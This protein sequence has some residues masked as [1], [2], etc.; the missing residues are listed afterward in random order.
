MENIATSAKK[1]CNYHFVKG[2]ERTDDKIVA[3]KA[4]CVLFYTLGKGSFRMLA[5]IFNTQPSLVYR[6]IMEAGAKLS[7]PKV[8]DGIMEMRV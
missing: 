1:E 6:W 7:D 5:K 4:M 8:A 3:K 2:D